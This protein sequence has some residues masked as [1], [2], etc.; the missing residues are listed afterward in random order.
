MDRGYWTSSLLSIW[1]LTLDTENLKLS[2]ISLTLTSVNMTPVGDVC[3]A[4]GA[5]I[6]AYE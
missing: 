1:N 5:K 3:F 2:Q 4:R 6:S